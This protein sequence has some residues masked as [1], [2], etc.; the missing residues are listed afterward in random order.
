MT[1][2]IPLRLLTVLLPQSGFVQQ[3]FYTSFA[4]SVRPW[5][6]SMRSCVANTTSE[7]ASLVERTTNE[8]LPA[9]FCDRILSPCLRYCRFRATLCPRSPG[10]STI[11]GC[12]VPECRE[13]C[14]SVRRAI[15]ADSNPERKNYRNWIASRVDFS[16]YGRL[17]RQ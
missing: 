15:S 7:S 13:T 2:F 1:Q 12:L 16:W 14:L 4:P 6:R 17:L 5:P 11:C 8:G 10:Q 9:L 3:A